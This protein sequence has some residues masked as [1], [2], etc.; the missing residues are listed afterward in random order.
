MNKIKQNKITFFLILSTIAIIFSSLT[1][2]SLPVLFNYESKVTKIEKNFYKNF[3]LYLNSLGSISYKPFP[4]PHLIL[5]NASVNLSDSKE[6]EPLFNTSDLKVFISLRD[7]YSRS[8]KDFIYAE[9]LNT[10][11]NFTIFDLLNIRKH[12]YQKINKP[13]IFKN[14]KIFIKNKNNEVI[15]ISPIKKIDYKINNK[16]KNKTF[17]I[18]GEV[19]GL[20]F[21]SNWKR[22]YSNPK[23]SLNIINLFNP[24]IEIKNLYK[25]FGNKSF[26]G[27]T[28]ILYAK[29]KMKYNINFYNNK[30]KINSP[31]NKDINFNI[32]ADI[33]L[34]PFYFDGRLKIKNR[35]LENIIDNLLLN[36]LIYNEDFLGNFNGKIKFEFNN[37]NNRLIKNGEI[38]L[39]I[40]EKDITIRRA[41]F[42]LDKIGEI[43]TE[44]NFTEDQDQIKFF[45]KNHLII[46]N[47]IEFAKVFQIGS[48]KMK[49]IKNVYFNIEKSIGDTDFIISKIQTNE[50]ET[51][52]KETDEI[53]SVKNIQNLR[54][55]I[56]KFSD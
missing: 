26:N 37:L 33:L 13:I 17:T 45:S 34:D 49:K 41:K 24:S 55:V 11:L 5:E 10:N 19:F 40:D 20:D 28:E 22:E 16:L 56:R 4:K 43:N 44:I 46:K 35:K 21:K 51:N 29:D 39:N 6:N 30:I 15:L 31:Q 53:Y 36:L 9:I 1:I 32:N 25:F 47:H 3:K 38:I 27:I 7:I 14:C 18:E 8:F 54:A 42:E 2:L 23:T 48:K 50:K 12:L 52:S